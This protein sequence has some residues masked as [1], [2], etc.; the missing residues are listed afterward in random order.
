[1]VREG[2]VGVGVDRR[3]SRAGVL[4]LPVS[5]NGDVIPGAVQETGVLEA[6][7]GLGNPA[8]QEKFPGTAVDEGG[9]SEGEQV[10]RGRDAGRGRLAIAAWLRSSVREV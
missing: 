2:V 9:G 10:M 8:G 4:Q 1:M 7:G 6:R 3:V 5:G